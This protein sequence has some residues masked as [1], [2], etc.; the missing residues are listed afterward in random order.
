MNIENWDLT[1]TSMKHLEL[2]ITILSLQHNRML[3]YV[4]LSPDLRTHQLGE[5]SS[6]YPWKATLIPQWTE[7]TLLGRKEENMG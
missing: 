3:E 5:A 6:K 4:A 1:H 7:P 2:E